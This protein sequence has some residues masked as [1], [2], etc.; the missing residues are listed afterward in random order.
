M[1]TRQTRAKEV[2]EM[3]SETETIVK[4]NRPRRRILW[5]SALLGIPVLLL[6]LAYLGYQWHLDR[7]CRAAI[8]DAGRRDRG[9]RLAD[10]EAARSDIPDKEN[11][12]LQILA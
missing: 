10:L 3:N 8:E 5:W 4:T 6:V 11:A 1:G 12:A 2:G 9:W 7:E